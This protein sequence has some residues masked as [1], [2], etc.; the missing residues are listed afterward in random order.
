[1]AAT[2]TERALR[3]LFIGDVVGRVG[4]DAVTALLPSL[5]R[6]H[7]VDVTI[8]NA[9]NAAG[10][11]GV[12]DRTVGEL[13]DAGV[14]VLTTGDHVWDRQ[15]AEELLDGDL[16]LLRPANY[17]PDTPGRGCMVFSSPEAGS[18]AVLS[19]QG[20]TFMKPLDCPFHVGSRLVDR[21]RAESP[22]VIVDFHAE[23]T[24]EKIA[25]AWHLAGRA[26]A[27][28]GTHTH[29]QTS[30][31]RIVDGHTAA[32]TDVGMTGPVD[33]VIGMKKE[34][35]LR[36]F[37]TGR[38]AR[39]KIGEGRCVLSAVVLDVDGETGAARSIERVCLHHG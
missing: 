17:P 8:A 31:E 10:G 7:G 24:S 39:Y 29:V 20:R 18:V 21:L 5:A 3:I 36:R 30:D 16:P 25:L 22:V 4:R 12:T 11:L 34:V 27:V 23:A 1:V 15:E 2:R 19:L 6:D 35:A 32:I 33:S 26:T 37:V 9:E 28:I 13:L 38:P 14:D